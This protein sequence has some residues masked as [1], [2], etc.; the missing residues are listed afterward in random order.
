MAAVG[1]GHL[2]LK[3]CGALGTE[4]GGLVIEL[5][6]ASLGAFGISGSGILRLERSKPERLELSPLAGESIALGAQLNYPLRRRRELGPLGCQRSLACGDCLV[7]GEKVRVLLNELV[8]GCC[9][10]LTLKPERCPLGLDLIA[11]GGERGS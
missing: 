7:L 4:L 6:C 9:Q 11:I 1:G 8:L 5:S 3:Q 2:L 10:L